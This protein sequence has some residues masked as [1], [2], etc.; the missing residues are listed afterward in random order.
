MAKQ[1]EYTSAAKALRIHADPVRSATYRS[2]FK[3]SGTDHFLGVPTPVLRRLAKDFCGMPLKEVRKLMQSGIHEERSLA[4]EILRLKFR[5]GDDRQ[6]KQ[7]FDFY[8][9]NKKL[10]REWDGVDGTAPYIAGPYLLNRDKQV[11]YELARSPRIWDRRIAIVSTWWFIRNGQIDHTFKLAEILL[12]DRE[13]LI[14]K[15]VGWMLRETGK[16]DVAELRKFLKLHSKD[17]PRTMLRYAI[18]R[19]TPEERKKWMAK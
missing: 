5:G 1:L 9:R 12:Q 10:I 15:A 6:Q 4:A 17:M 14:H 3:D 16:Q 7:I 18:E 13:D 19:F 8:L 2:F 11:L